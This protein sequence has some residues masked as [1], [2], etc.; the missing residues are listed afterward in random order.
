[1]LWVVRVMP[2]ITVAETEEISPSV[3]AD[4]ARSS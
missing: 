1:V 3:R 4:Q 2:K